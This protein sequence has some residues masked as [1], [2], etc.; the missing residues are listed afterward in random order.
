MRTIFIGDAHLRGTS[1]E[2][3]K[4]FCNFLDTIVSDD[5]KKVVIMGDLFDF[6]YGYNDVVYYHYLP[7]LSALDKLKKAGVAISY[8]EGNH[9]FKLGPYFSKELAIEVFEE[10]FVLNMNGKKMLIMHG[11]TCDKSISY[12]FW[13]ALVRSIPMSILVKTLSPSTIWKVA[14][15]LSKNSRLYNDER[16][17]NVDAVL[18]EQATKKIIA[19]YDAVVMGHSHLLGIHDIIDGN[20]SG[21]YVNTGSWLNKEY[22][23]FD[24]GRFI[25]KNYK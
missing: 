13:R 15:F 19:G 24:E 9:D 8:I 12:T 1:D 7:V 14:R 3:Q 2:N 25:K 4:D 6:W 10:S 20:I 23:L 21:K 11:D 17:R 22:I 16:G 18:K 5:I